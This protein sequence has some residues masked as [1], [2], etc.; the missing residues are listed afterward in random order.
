MIKGLYGFTSA[1]ALV[2]TL[3]LIPEYVGIIP[4]AMIFLCGGLF[5]FLITKIIEEEQKSGGESPQ[6]L[7]PPDSGPGQIPVYLV[8]RKC[9]SSQIYF[10]RWVSPNLRQ[11]RPGLNTGSFF[12]RTGSHVPARK[13][14][15]RSQVPG[16]KKP[17]LSRAFYLFLLIYK[18]ACQLQ[19][20]YLLSHKRFLAHHLSA[21][22]HRSALIKY[23]F[24]RHLYFYFPFVSP[25]IKQNN[26]NR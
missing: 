9:Q 11:R 15:S 19:K 14:R 26:Y 1:C 24:H 7:W 21:R 3:A 10:I 20:F 4:G 2:T 8:A 18:A 17:G 22:H 13:L 12:L 16:I 25:I 6:D 5:T 23:L